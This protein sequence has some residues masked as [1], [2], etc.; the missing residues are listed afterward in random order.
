MKCCNTKAILTVFIFITAFT[1]SKPEA[2]AQN[3]PEV[4]GI[5]EN[6]IE[7]KLNSSE[8]DSVKKAVDEALQKT[9]ISGAYGFNSEDLLTDALKG[10]PIKNLKG[11]PK[12]MLSVL[13]KEIKANLALI[14]EL[15]AVM[16]LGAVIRAMQPLEDGI[17]N[18]AAKLSVNGVMVVI[19]SISFGSVAETAR[20]A[21]ESMQNVAAIAM[22]ALIAM[23]ASAGQIV[24]FT[25]IQPIMLF[26]VN[27]AC[28]LCKTVLLPLAVMSGIIF[29]VDSVSERFKLK[30]LAKLL[31][32]CTSWLTGAVAL[33]FSILISIQKL[34]GGSVDAAAIKTTKFAI[35]TFV[36]VAGKYMS[37]AAETIL[38]CTSAV[39]NAAGAITVIGL[40]LV[41]INPFIKVL[42]IMLSFRLAA[43]LGSP[44]CDECT[45]NALEDAAGCISLMIGIMGASL[46]VLIL[47]TGAM[48][49]SVGLMK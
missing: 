38:I 16:L 48:M 32:S 33:L 3:E 26:A 41:V 1:V 23:M 34:A 4:S 5:S 28:Q 20:S 12:I 40:G 17:P 9:E 31:K 24:S 46:F 36:P 18:A 42:V 2:F 39:R 8:V 14:L 30:T 49:S 44:I 45:S 22:P 29:L 19:A 10:N 35:N 43:A 21:I 7:E 47:L 25:A 37:E 11:L 6:I 27:T 15:F 13:G